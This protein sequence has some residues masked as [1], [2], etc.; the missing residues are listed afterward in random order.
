MNLDFLG[1]DKAQLALAGALGGVVRWMTLRDHWTD[2]LIAIF[3]G[4]V[5][6][7][8][9]SPLAIPALTPLLGGLQVAPESTLGVSGFLMGIG[10]IT[11]AGFVIDLVR[12]RRRMLK[13][14]TEADFTGGEDGDPKP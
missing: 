2:G 1:W 7:L 8:Y 4:A 13:Q 6:S 14:S 12:A 9:L 3:V 5:C 10:G 11:F